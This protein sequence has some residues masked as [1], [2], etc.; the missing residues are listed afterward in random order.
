MHDNKD[1]KQGLSFCCSINLFGYSLYILIAACPHL[2]VSHHTT[3]SSSLLLFSSMKGVDSQGN[4]PPWQ[5]KSMQ[6]YAHPFLLRPDKAAKQ[7]NQDLQASN[8]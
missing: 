4:N 8:N 6:D 1:L 7:G 5:I 3:P 2:P